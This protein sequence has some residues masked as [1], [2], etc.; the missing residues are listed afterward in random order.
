MA[1]R[2]WRHFR[3]SYQVSLLGSLASM[4]WFAVVI[5]IPAGLLIA[6]PFV[7][8][9]LLLAF[10]IGKETAAVSAAGATLSGIAT[11]VLSGMENA[12]RWNGWLKQ[13]RFGLA[14][15]LWFIFSSLFRNLAWIIVGMS[16]LASCL[17]VVT[18]FTPDERMVPL[19]TSFGV[20]WLTALFALCVASVMSVRGGSDTPFRGR[21][22]TSGKHKAGKMAKKNR[23]KL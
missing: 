11:L 4:V 20:S 7:I 16:V 22:I 17:K 23:W 14:S 18:S 2:G 15:G 21:R 10:G 1:K 9:V 6:V 8:A 3:R 19:M 12:E 13:G 5:L